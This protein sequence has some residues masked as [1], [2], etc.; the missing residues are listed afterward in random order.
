MEN[1]VDANYIKMER[2]LCMEKKVAKEVFN[3]TCSNS[4][5]NFTPLQIFSFVMGCVV[6]TALLVALWF[7]TR[8]SVR[9]KQPY[10]SVN[11]APPLSL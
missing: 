6:C 2:P 5:I 4:K 10:T 8:K 11:S 9:C 3:V 1:L 7:L